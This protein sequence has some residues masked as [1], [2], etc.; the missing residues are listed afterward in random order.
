[1]V[2]YDLRT[3]PLKEGMLEFNFIGVKNKKR[4]LAATELGYHPRALL[5]RQLLG[6]A[7]TSFLIGFLF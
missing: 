7:F 6:I 3:N 1:L 2:K 5:I 4:R